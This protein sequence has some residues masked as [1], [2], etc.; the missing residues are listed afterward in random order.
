[1][2]VACSPQEQIKK[3]ADLILTNA[4]VYTMQWQESS[5]EGELSSEAPYNVG[6]RPDAEAIVIQN[7]IITYVG[8]TRE[9]LNYQN[10]ESRIIDL[11]G[12]TILPGLVDSHT[13]IFGVGAAL[14]RVNLIGVLT[15]E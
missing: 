11:A 12:A 15:E 4:R 7:N 9:A 1:M 2:I 6:W 14:E 3:E 5:S 13:H 10:D 8:K